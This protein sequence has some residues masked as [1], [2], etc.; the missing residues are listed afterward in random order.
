LQEE[1]ATSVDAPAPAP[2]EPTATETLLKSLEE[3]GANFP[4]PEAVVKA[5]TPLRA[6]SEGPRSARSKAQGEPLSAAAAMSSVALAF[7]VSRTVENG[8]GRASIASAV[9]GEEVL[10]LTLFGSGKD[11][12]AQ[13][14]SGSGGNNDQPPAP[15]SGSKSSAKKRRSSRK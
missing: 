10:P 14:A 4:A 6:S 15:A 11:T 7:S 2:A 8:G 9:A 5:L 3:Q 1:T 12:V 13:P